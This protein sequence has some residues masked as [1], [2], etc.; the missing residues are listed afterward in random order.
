MSDDV[1]ILFGAFRQSFMRVAPKEF[2]NF[3][4]NQFPDIPAKFFS[5]PHQSWYHKGIEIWDENVGWKKISEDI[6]QSIECIYNEIKDFKNVYFIGSSMGGYAA[7]LFAYLINKTKNFK[8]KKV[9]TYLPQIDLNIEFDDLRTNTKKSDFDNKYMDLSQLELND[10][11]I[12]IH[13]S[14]SFTSSNSSHHIGH[15]RK[16][17]KFSN[18]NIIEHNDLIL[19]DYRD[20]GFLYKDFLSLFK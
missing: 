12:D 19:K 17:K 4:L 6:N 11:N 8:V 18:I 3:I 7:I 20:N 16:M 9:L 2:N 14:L 15:V 10:L 1:F 5:D 13:G